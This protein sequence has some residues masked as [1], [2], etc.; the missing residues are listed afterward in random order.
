MDKIKAT[1]EYKLIEKH[2]EGKR[3]R[4]SGVPLINHINEGLI[5][6]AEIGSSVDAMRAFCLHPLVQSDE[7]LTEN[8]Y[9]SK[10]V[11]PYNMMLVMEYR[12]VAND[13]LSDRVLEVNSPRL[14]PLIEVNQMLIA[15]KVQN[16]KD[17]VR[18]HKS[19]HPR[20]TELE[21][22]FSKWLMALGV[23]SD[24]YE[25]FVKKIWDYK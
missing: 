21:L 8:Y 5:V 6:L 7:A 23:T 12:S 24:S 11:S 25:N 16:Y 19:T 22:Y 20:S 18:Y 1:M 10:Y 14:S 4:R 3:A 17:F 15:D 2:Y 13:F 9:I